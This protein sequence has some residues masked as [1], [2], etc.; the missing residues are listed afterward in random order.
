MKNEKQIKQLE[1]E[2][3]DIQ[4]EFAGYTETR[5]QSSHKLLDYN[6]HLRYLRVNPP[7]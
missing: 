2:L 5:F 4:Q 1:E 3:D 6:P 7:Q